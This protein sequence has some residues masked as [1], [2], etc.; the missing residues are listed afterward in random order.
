M[1]RLWF[2]TALLPGGWSE[3]VRISAAGGCIESV[4][5]GVEPGTED[6]RHAIGVPGLGNLHSH[7]FQRGLAGL[8]E[9][10]DPPTTLSGAGGS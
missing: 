1:T 3:G 2:A 9:V 8:T 4:E 6:E 10:G 5:T 7:S